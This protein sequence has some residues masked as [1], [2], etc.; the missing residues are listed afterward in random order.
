MEDDNNNFNV[1]W[2]KKYKIKSSVSTKIRNI[3]END[4]FF[5]RKIREVFD[6]QTIAEK[7]DRMAEQTANYKKCLDLLNKGSINKMRA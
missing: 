1:Q 5:L 3:F 7:S 4:L 2:E 6:I